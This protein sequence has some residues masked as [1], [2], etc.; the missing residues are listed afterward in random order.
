MRFFENVA[1]AL[2]Y[3]VMLGAL[4]VRNVSGANAAQQF[5]LDTRNLAGT[6][7]I[8][9]ACS[10]GTATLAISV[11]SDAVNWLTLDS[12]AAAATTVK[13]YTHTTVGASIALSPLAFRYVRIAA[14]SAGA[15]NTTT[16]TVGMK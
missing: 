2:S 1:N 10:A 4:R 5:D 13:Q 15:G 8:H 9:M 14:G 6:L 7:A 11:S 12:I 3:L 16:L